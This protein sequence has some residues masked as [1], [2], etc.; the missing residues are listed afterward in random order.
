MFTARNTRL[1][2]FFGCNAGNT[3]ASFQQLW[4]PSICFQPKNDHMELNGL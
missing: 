1:L 2:K 4:K 3:L